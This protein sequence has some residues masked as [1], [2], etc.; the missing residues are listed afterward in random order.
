MT[1]HT[2]LAGTLESHIETIVPV[3]Q[4]KTF[5]QAQAQHSYS[6]GEFFF[7]IE[8]T[9]ADACPVRTKYFYVETQHVDSLF[10]L[11]GDKGFTTP[12][13]AARYL[14]KQVKRAAERMAVVAKL[15]S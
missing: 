14:D 2:A 10:D 9:Y 11:D 3:S 5:E 1:A 4:A 6:I 7:T 8:R 12:E 13:A 15:V